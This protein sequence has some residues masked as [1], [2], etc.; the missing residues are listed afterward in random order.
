M[1]ILNYLEKVVWGEGSYKWVVVLNHNAGVF[2]SEEKMCLMLEKL[3]FG[4]LWVGFKAPLTL[5][6]FKTH[7]KSNSDL[8]QIPNWS[9]LGI[10]I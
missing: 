4:I 6:E 9:V 5:Q 3:G 10:P 2:H 8:A 7:T 1:A